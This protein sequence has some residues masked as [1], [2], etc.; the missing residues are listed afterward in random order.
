MTTGG[1]GPPLLLVHG[2]QQPGGHGACAGNQAVPMP[3]SRTQIYISGVAG[4][5]LSA[6][7]AWRQ[8]DGSSRVCH[9]S[10]DH[11]LWSLVRPR[12]TTGSKYVPSGRTSAVE[13]RMVW[14]DGVR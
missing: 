12:A 6:T 1:D 13:S 5:P 2:W 7:L 3:D 9:Q 10:A 4:M 11:A 14:R 8:I